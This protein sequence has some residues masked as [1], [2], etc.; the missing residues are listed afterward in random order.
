LR[1]ELE[2]ASLEIVVRI[3]DDIRVDRFQG[4]KAPWRPSP[5]TTVSS[6]ELGPLSSAFCIY[7]DKLGTP[8]K[9][10]IDSGGKPN[11]VPERR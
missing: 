3:S 6:L 4:H 1:V 8:V 9:V 7:A 11:G 2:C 10:N 5:V